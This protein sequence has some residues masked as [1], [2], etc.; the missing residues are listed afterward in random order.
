VNGIVK[1]SGNTCEML[2]TVAFII[3]DLSRMMTLEPGDIITTGTPAG[4]GFAR[5]PQEFL[6]PGDVLES[7]VEKIGMLR[8]RIV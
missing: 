7:A 1:Q 5:K 8:N 4:V 2:Y 6:K 3:E